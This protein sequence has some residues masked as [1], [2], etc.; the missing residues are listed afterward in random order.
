[1]ARAVV[2][3]DSGSSQ[4]TD[5]VLIA[6]NYAEE[7]VADKA[8]KE[9]GRRLRQAAKRFLD[10]LTRSLRKKPPFVFS[11]RKANAHCEFIEQLPH[12]EGEWH[13]ANITLEPAQIF[14]VVQLFGFRKLDGKR[15]FSQAAYVTARK[16]AKSTLAAAIM[17]SCM[18]LEPEPGAQLISAA[19]TGSQARI[20]WKVA[21]SM[22][23]KCEELREAFEMETFSNS[24]ARY[25]TGASYR[26]INSKASTQDGL[27]PS[28]TNLDEIHAHKNADLVNVLKSAAGARKNPLWLYTT[29]EG[30]DTPGPWPELRA[31]GYRVLEGV[32]EADHFLVCFW[33]MDEDDEPLD[34]SK[35]IKANPLMH[36]NPIILEE[37]RKLKIEA[38]NMPSTMAEFRIKRCNLP[39]ASATSWVNLHKW[40]K[41]AQAVDLDYLARN[42]DGCWGALDFA[43]TR[44]MNAWR[45]L[46]KLGADWY[47]WGRYW[48]PGQQVRERSERGAVPYQG[49]VERGNIKLTGGDTTDYEVVIEE[50]LADFARF[51]PSKVAYDSWNSQG[52]INRFVAEGMPMEAFIQGFKSYNPAMKTCERAYIDGL[53]HHGGDPVLKWNVANVVPSYDT[54]LSVKPDRKRSADKIDGAVCLF[55]CFGLALAQDDDGDA[56][57]FF[58]K[59]VSSQGARK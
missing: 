7:A 31:F 46:W 44:D 50:V 35:W 11:A 36:V 57:G 18:A 56:A 32:V 41:C 33:M 19:T 43:S 45:L 3:R 53:L 15:R 27:N 16:N 55:M 8:G 6:I 47:T 51:S 26:P 28:T 37:M 12:I 49:W 59:P 14:F 42:A 24:I 2:S 34:E 13:T 10:D 9:H 30:Y 20:V 4:Q 25:D 23:D 17:I 58:A 38:A 39:A 21:K 48:V 40:N 22:I 54:N 52:I 1:M 29:T 5:Y